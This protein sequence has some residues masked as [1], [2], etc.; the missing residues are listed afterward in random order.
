MKSWQFSVSG[1]QVSGI[2]EI[3]ENQDYSQ[4]GISKNAKWVEI[5][6]DGYG[7]LVETKLVAQCGNQSSVSQNI[8]EEQHYIRPFLL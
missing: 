5:C 3:E 4:S 8:T 2:G 6:T 1:G 7:K